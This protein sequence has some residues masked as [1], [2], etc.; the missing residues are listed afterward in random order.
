MVQHLILCCR[1]QKRL[2]LLLQK[3]KPVLPMNLKLLLKWKHRKVV[4]VSMANG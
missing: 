1:E 4:V 2:K 3:Q